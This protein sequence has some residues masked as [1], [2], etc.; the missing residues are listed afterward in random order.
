[1]MSPAAALALFRWS[2]AALVISMF[3]LVFVALAP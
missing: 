3:L 2:I 1:M